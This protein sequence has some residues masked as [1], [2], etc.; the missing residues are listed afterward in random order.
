V[1]SGTA[2]ET[3]TPGKAYTITLDL[4][5]T[6]HVV[7]KGH[8]LALIVAGSDKDLIDPPSSTP[9]LTVDLSRTAAHMPLVGGAA[10]FGRAVSGGAP[11]ASRTT[12]QDGVRT[13]LTV[14]AVPGD[15]L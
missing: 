13:P 2:T 3:L 15:S 14:H 7:P 4:A 8:R 5:A 12:A 1:P 9:T 6:D 10:A 11:A